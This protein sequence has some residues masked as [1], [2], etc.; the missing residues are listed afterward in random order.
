MPC[1]S[2]RSCRGRTRHRT[3]SRPRPP[4]W[5]GTA[6]PG[7]RCGAGAGA[8]AKGW[9]QCQRSPRPGLNLRQPRTRQLPRRR[10][11]RWRGGAGAGAVPVR[12]LDLGKAGQATGDRGLL[13]RSRALRPGP[14]NGEGLRRRLPRP[15]PVKLD[16]ES[17]VHRRPL[18]VRLR[19][20]P[21]DRHAVACGPADSAV[22]G[23]L[24]R[25]RRGGCAA[26][27]IRVQGLV[28]PRRSRKCGGHPRR[29]APHSRVC[30]GR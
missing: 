9:R 24:R 1:S 11:R 23:A 3:R 12:C 15:S 13:L 14:P 25:A 10:R 27:A 22:W 29:G 26:R 28:G 2:P 18:G 17:V 6:A 19:I 20:L 30:T 5:L 21:G 16:P 4:P 7:A 8:G